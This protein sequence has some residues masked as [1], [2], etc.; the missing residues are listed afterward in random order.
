M[1]MLFPVAIIFNSRLWSFSQIG[2]SA[3]SQNHFPENRR[4]IC[5]GERRQV[6]KHF[7][8][9]SHSQFVVIIE[10][11][12]CACNNPPRAAAPLQWSVATH[13]GTTVPTYAAVTSALCFTTTFSIKSFFSYPICILLSTHDSVNIASQNY[14][15]KFTYAQFLFDPH[16]CLGLSELLQLSIR[17]PKGI[18][19]ASPA[20]TQ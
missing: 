14:S 10:T 13:S 1:F 2:I 19:I 9:N 11:P 4:V 15:W 17:Y 12:I 8:L 7:Y 18:Y 16:L 20:F 6:E 5:V 3:F